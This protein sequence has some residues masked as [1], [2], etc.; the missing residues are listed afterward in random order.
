M[1][2]DLPVCLII[3]NRRH[4]YQVSLVSFPVCTKSIFWPWPRPKPTFS[5]VN[6]ANDLKL[7]ANPQLE[8]ICLSRLWS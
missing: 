7:A 2:N 3:Y 6:M 4:M 1:A 5:D 8:I